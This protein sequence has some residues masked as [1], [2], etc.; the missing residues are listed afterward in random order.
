MVTVRTALIKLADLITA[1]IAIVLLVLAVLVVIDL[2]S[3]FVPQINLG[4]WLSIL[5]ILAILL[6]IA[7]FGASVYRKRVQSRQEREEE[8]KLRSEIRLR[9]E[10]ILESSTGYLSLDDEKAKESIVQDISSS[11]APRYHLYKLIDTETELEIAQALL[12]NIS[13]HTPIEEGKQLFLTY[14][15]LTKYSTE[16]AQL[17]L[18]RLNKRKMRQHGTTESAFLRL[19]TAYDKTIAATFE[20]LEAQAKEL[21]KEELDVAVVDVTGQGLIYEKIAETAKNERRYENLKRIVSVVI[22]QGYI[23][24]RGLLPFLQ[25]EGDILC[26]IKSEAGLSSSLRSLF[27][28]GKEMTPFKKV[29][30][31]Y[32]FV[33]PSRRDY[34]TFILPSSRIPQQYRQSV[35]L[36]MEKEIIPRVCKEW[37]RLYQTY[38]YKRLQTPTYGYLA[39]IVKRPDM[40]WTRVNMQFR[41]QFEDQILGRLTPSQTAKLIVTQIHSIPKIL[42]QMEADSLTTVA[43]D[44]QKLALR[45]SEPEMRKEIENQLGISIRDIADY[46]KLES[47]KDAFSDILG[48]WVNEKLSPRAW[49]KCDPETAHKITEEIVSNAIDIKNLI[50]SLGVKI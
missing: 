11:F 46:S 35:H 42:R 16:N 4:A 29:L 40:S 32:G 9:L 13:R 41:Q 47:S 17:F 25:T 3:R 50:E 20:E 45:E 38:G 19:L 44:S 12:A 21:A 43:T 15:Y 2:A 1:N 18:D 30:L 5:D 14:L 23:S 27:M 22:N 8:E 39:F 10:R 6:T 26:V 33:Q 28:S 36:F 24:T 34:F 31:D 7:S 37:E 49:K 48:R